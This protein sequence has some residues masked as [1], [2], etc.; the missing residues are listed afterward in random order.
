MWSYEKRLLFPVKITRPDLHMAKLLLEPYAGAT[1]SLTAAMTYLSQRYSMPSGALKALLTDVGTEKLSHMEML[2]SMIVQCLAGA[3]QQ[4]LTDAGLGSL[5]TTHGRSLF[6]EDSQGR[7]W[8]AAYTVCSGDA[9]SDIAFDIALENRLH[10][11]YERLISLCDDKGFT[12]PLA[13]LC[14]R[15]IVHHQRF[16]EAMEMIT[17]EKE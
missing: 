9:Q 2:A 16:T 17:P 10:V 13:F 14:Q 4:E 3:S 15:G 11:Q 8:S 7:P 1:S 6:A 5:F 12:E